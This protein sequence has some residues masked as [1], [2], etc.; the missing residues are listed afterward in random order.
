MV[1]RFTSDGANDH[2]L[3]E[4]IAVVVN[5]HDGVSAEW[6][7]TAQGTRTSPTSWT[8]VVSL[9]P[10]REE[11]L[12]EIVDIRWPESDLL[13]PPWVTVGEFLHISAERTDIEIGA[14][15]RPAIAKAEDDRTLLYGQPLGAIA[16]GSS[17]FRAVAVV[18]DCY[19]TK[20]LFIPGIEA[21]PLDWPS[22]GAD[23]Y[24][25]LESATEV[26]GFAHLGF[27]PAWMAIHAGTQYPAVGV[28]ARSI[29]ATDPTVAH[30]MFL[31]AVEVVGGLLAV[32][33]DCAP[34]PTAYTL[35]IRDQS[36]GEWRGL[37][38]GPFGTPYSGATGAGPAA[39]ES[40]RELVAWFESWRSAPRLQLWISQWSSAIATEHWD[41]QCLA[42][43]TLLEGMSR[44]LI[45]QPGRPLASDGTQLSGW[46]GKVSNAGIARSR[47]Y[48]LLMRVAKSLEIE[49][50]EFVSGKESD[51]WHE[52]GIWVDIRDAVAHHG[53][54]MAALQPGSAAD[55]RVLD[56]VHIVNP[57]NPG[58]G[59]QAVQRT[60]RG[61][62]RVTLSALL[63]GR[64]PSAP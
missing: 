25:L 52:V 27:R 23:T 55:Q 40:Q 50:T 11:V 38:T 56:Y 46:D 49:A 8:A 16:S 1:L 9:P 2:S 62:A 45:P 42:I 19:L 44:E 54:W 20:S 7:Q 61:A 58:E 31:Q 36:S 5:R 47:V 28:V 30:K 4:R 17:E 51:L 43:V 41:R 24:R 34:R 32:A 57:S 63:A 39:G 6:Y 12:L 14:S 21:F 22:R 18:E 15:V 60:L 53:S 13:S 10:G 26:A 33:R 3:G 29:Y 59:L 35:E 64:L 37:M 48:Q